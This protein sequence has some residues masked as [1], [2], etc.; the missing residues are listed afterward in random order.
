MPKHATVA[1]GWQYGDTILILTNDEASVLRSVLQHV[2]GTGKGRKITDGIDACL[3][4]A[5]VDAIDDLLNGSV[6]FRQ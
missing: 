3:R 5:G 6:Y 1:G 2:G 4:D